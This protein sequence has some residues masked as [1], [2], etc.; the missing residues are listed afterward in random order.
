MALSDFL[1]TWNMPLSRQQEPNPPI[2]STGL[3]EI[4]EASESNKVDYTFT[5]CTDDE[6]THSG[7]GDYMSASDT[8]EFEGQNND[9]AFD[10]VFAKV[11]D[12]KLEITSGTMTPETEGE[13][14]TIKGGPST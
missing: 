2:N 10:G 5:R 11:M 3:V 14:F 9:W 12:N 1:G 6:W 8:I 13:P 4:T 7:S